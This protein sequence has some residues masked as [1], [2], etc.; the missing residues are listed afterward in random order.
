MVNKSLCLTADSTPEQ[1]A[2]SG[3]ENKNPDSTG[4]AI[5]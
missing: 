3:D 4:N 1:Y 5:L 2:G